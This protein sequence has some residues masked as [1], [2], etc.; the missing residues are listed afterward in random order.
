MK[1]FDMK[2]LS[3]GGDQVKRPDPSAVLRKHG[4][5]FH[6]ASRLLGQRYRLR[7][8]RLYAFCRHVDDLAD[9]SDDPVAAR[10]D[11]GDLRSQLVDGRPHDAMASDFLALAE[12]TAMPIAPAL[13]L[14]DGALDDIDRHPVSSQAELVRYGYQVAGTVGLMMCAV[15]D[16][17]RREAL[18]FA[19]DL[20]IAMQLTN[21]ARDVGED[22]VMGRVYLP[23]EWLESMPAEAIRAPDAV[24][25]ERLRRATERTLGLAERYYE[26]G[27]QGL[28]FLPAGARY[29]I[30]V[31]A[32]V[33]RQIG[34]RIA[35]EDFRTWDRRCIVPGGA[36]LL[37]AGSALR[38]H[39]AARL[40]GIGRVEH[41]PRLH[42]QLRGLFGTNRSEARPWHQPDILTY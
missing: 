12:D 14:I 35:A 27:L 3:P 39:T 2:D 16:V 32:Q 26:S 20:G 24:Q 21:I 28:R 19:I 8:A 29:A 42:R 6:F 17:R 22:A 7:S 1:R 4:R 31:A 18:P 38:D 40:S 15:L 34:C 36:K 5:T 13:A 11:L 9:L 41:D 10:G 25:A 37:R 30:L 33:Y 23:A